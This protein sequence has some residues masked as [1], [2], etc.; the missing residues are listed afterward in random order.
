MRPATMLGDAYR[1]EKVRSF[2]HLRENRYKIFRL[3][4]RHLQDATRAERSP[5]IA[6]PAAIRLAHKVL[7]VGRD[8]HLEPWADQWAFLAS[9][10][11]I[12]R[13]Q[14]ERIVQDAERRGRI[15]GVRLPPQEDG[16]DEPWT[17]P[18]S[19]RRQEPPILGALPGNLELVLGN[20]IDI[21]K[22]GLHPA[23]RNQLLGLAAFQN[24]EFSKA[25]AMRVSTYGKPRVMAC[26]EDHAHH[27][28]VPRRCLD[29]VRKV[30]TDL[31]V[32]TT[33]RDEV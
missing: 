6:R 11:K 7:L 21:A 19:R 31:G 27:I 32:R 17:A 9:V 16:E 12:D 20:Q 13:A 22:D 4:L 28:G 33:I 18:P 30:L 24:P 3:S 25:Q 14:I 5:P 8:D 29:D 2:M 15:L 23:L 26:A 10:R 1:R